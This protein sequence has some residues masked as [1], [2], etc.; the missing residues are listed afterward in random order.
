MVVLCLQGAQGVA[1]V[2]PMECTRLARRIWADRVE[3]V[4]RDSSLGRGAP[5]GPQSVLDSDA[6]DAGS[7][8][9]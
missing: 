4:T 7:P 8:M 6:T 3:S 1:S 2:A 5:P 9:H